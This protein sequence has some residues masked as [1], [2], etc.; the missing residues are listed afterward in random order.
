MHGLC[1]SEACGIFPDQGSNLCL[2]L[3]KYGL[4]TNRLSGM[5]F[6]KTKLSRFYSP[7]APPSSPCL[8]LCPLHSQSRECFSGLLCCNL[9]GVEVSE[10]SWQ[11]VVGFPWGLQVQPSQ[12]FL[13]QVF[14]VEKGKSQ[15]RK[16]SFHKVGYIT[17]K[18]ILASVGF[19]N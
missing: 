17:L 4:L 16:G 12:P 2:L 13:Q 3:W 6:L 1:C 14:L 11:P 18:P 7:P 10:K 5:F 9:L 15:L 19:S 8:M